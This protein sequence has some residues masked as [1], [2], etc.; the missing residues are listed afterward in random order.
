MHSI[1]DL[2]GIPNDIPHRM[3]AIFDVAW[4]GY[5]PST[6]LTTIPISI[7]HSMTIQHCANSTGIPHAISA[8]ARQE[9]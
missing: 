4:R 6:N 2:T 8:T 7:S 3:A 1:S 5:L 9:L